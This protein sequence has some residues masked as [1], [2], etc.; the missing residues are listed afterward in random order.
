MGTQKIHFDIFAK[1]MAKAY[2][3]RVNTLFYN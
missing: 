3:N 2:T 1:K